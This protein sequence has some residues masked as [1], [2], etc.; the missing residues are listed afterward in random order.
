MEEKKIE[1][2]RPFEPFS[3]RVIV[4]YLN[5]RTKPNVNSALGLSAPVKRGTEFEVLDEVT[6]QIGEIWYKIKMDERSIYINSKYVE[7]IKE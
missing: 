2:K 7:R 5:V 1:I 6:T 3:V 4:D